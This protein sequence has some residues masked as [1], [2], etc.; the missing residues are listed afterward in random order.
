MEPHTK[1]AARG[2]TAKVIGQKVL[3]PREQVEEK[4]RTAIL[5]GEL[6][7]GERLPPEAELAR[8]FDVSRTTVREALRSL[9]SQ[10]LIDKT[11]GVGGGSFVRS[12]DHQSLGTLLQESLHN[13]L[14]LGSLR[15]EEV[16]MLRQYLEVP[17]ARLAAR[18]RSDEDL[19]KLQDIVE[20]QKTISVDDPDVPDLDARFHAAI[21]KASGNR[22]LASF[23]HALHRETEPVHYLDLSP[24]V[25][26][27]TVRQHQKI[28]K[29]IAAA[30]PDA[31]EEAVNEHLM[32]LREHVLS[33]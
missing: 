25:G 1:R 4:I 31:A 29:A 13:L 15:V 5:S 12:I 26:R 16:A 8:Q 19:A 6:R 33:L 22:L 30:D 18:H 7:S 24:Q 17:A 23:V 20:R 3:R 28:V 2:A 9:V 11:P 27:A 21:A 14:Q 10:K 32:Y